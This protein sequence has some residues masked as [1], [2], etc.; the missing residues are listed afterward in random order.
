MKKFILSIL[1]ISGVFYSYAVELINIKGGEFTRKVEVWN[2]I[3]TQKI[4]LDDFFISKYELTVGEYIE[5]LQS[6]NKVIPEYL[7]AY[8]EK[9]NP[10]I[11]VGFISFLEA[12]EYC[13]WLSRKEKLISCYNINGSKVKWNYNAN[14]YRLPTEAEWEYAATNGWKDQDMISNDYE[15]IKKYTYENSASLSFE[16]YIPHEIGKVR[17]NILGLYDVLDNVAEWCW[18]LFNVDYFDIQTVL[19]NPTGPE[20]GYDERY[21]DIQIDN[22]VLKGGVIIKHNNPILWTV[23]EFPESRNFVGIRL[24]RN[25]E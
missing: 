9:N 20:E 3:R 13:N 22:R 24:A 1:I 23:S 5:Y 4:R 10:R 21:S 14:G 19:I 2:K 11:A 8:L 15:I 17:P 16:D 25:A 6:E 12:I 18:D 7:E